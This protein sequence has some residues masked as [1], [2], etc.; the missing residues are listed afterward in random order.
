MINGYTGYD[1]ASGNLDAGQLAK[2]LGT[3]GA[4]L[5]IMAVFKWAAKR[6]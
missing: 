3:V 2:G 5:V 1:I 6:F 4:G